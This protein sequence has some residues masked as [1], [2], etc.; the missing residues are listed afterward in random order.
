MGIA[1]LFMTSVGL[2]ADAFAASLCQGLS[3]KRLKIK[4]ALTVAGLFGLFQALMPLIG[5]F[6]ASFFAGYIERFDHF[7]A[8]G[9]LGFL[10]IKMIADAVKEKN[11]SV[12]MP[13]CGIKQLVILAIATSIDALA[14]GIMFA[15]FASFNIFPAVI[16]IGAVTFTLSFVGVGI[17]FKFGVKMKMGAGI[18]GGAVLIVIG[19]KILLEHLGI[20]SF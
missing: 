17:G 19:A 11:S 4:S 1:E 7:I 13:K 20:I 9:L 14:V 2:S 5:Y 18:A 6:C 10:G 12:E 15:S 16:L 3:M 8:F